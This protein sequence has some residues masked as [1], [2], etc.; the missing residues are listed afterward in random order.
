[1]HRQLDLFQVLDDAAGLFEFL[2]VLPEG[3]HQ[4]FGVLGCQDD[5]GFYP[6]FWCARHNIDEIQDEFGV[7]VGNDR[8]VGILS[9]CDLF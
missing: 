1:M 4:S 9:I 5:P 3:V 8:E 6:A 2:D 7:A